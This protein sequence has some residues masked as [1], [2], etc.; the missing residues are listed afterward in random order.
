MVK[1]HAPFVR[2]L[3]SDKTIKSPL[4]N[5]LG[6]QVFRTVAAQACY[7]M[8]PTAKQPELT[9]TLN[10]LR[11]DG[12]V[13]VSNFLPDEQFTAVVK[14]AEELLVQNQ[15]RV[16]RLQHGPNTVE[17]LAAQDARLQ[18]ALPEFF[19][20]PMV[21]ALLDSAE[22]RRGAASRAHGAIERLTQGA[23]LDDHDPETDLHSD[24]FFNTHKVWLYLTDVVAESAPLVYVKGSHLLS[25]MALKYAYRESC[26]GNAGSRR[27]T[28][29]ELAD[30][31]LV[32]TVF[33]C[34][35]NTLVIANVHGYHRRLRGAPGS[36]RLS[37]HLSHRVNPFSWR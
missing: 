31:G 7:R 26:S 12:A 37:L 19:S 14:N 6:A 22:R 34:P 10:A 32:E 24:I 11:R 2:I 21:A 9:D 15:D 27:I 5:R 17:V 1:A 4:L 18:E 13:T 29:K 33:T 16:K 23:N 8:R 36:Q 28:Q 35:R 20:N 25:R 3:S 30:L